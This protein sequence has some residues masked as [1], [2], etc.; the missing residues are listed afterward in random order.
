M[1]RNITTINSKNGYSPGE[2]VVHETHGLGQIVAVENKTIGSKNVMYCAIDSGD[3]TWWVPLAGKKLLRVLA[4]PEDT[5]VPEEM[6]T[7]WNLLRQ[8]IA[9]NQA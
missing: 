3:F 8:Q 9:E 4:P 1:A 6:I 7:G 5:A 2:W